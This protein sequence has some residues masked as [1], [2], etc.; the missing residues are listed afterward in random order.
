VGPSGEFWRFL[1]GQR[2]YLD[3]YDTPS[4]SFLEGVSH[5]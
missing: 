2:A 3:S 1:S 4:T 5:D